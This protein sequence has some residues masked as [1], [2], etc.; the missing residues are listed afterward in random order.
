MAYGGRWVADELRSVLDPPR[1][2]S[3]SMTEHRFV[4]RSLASLVW[5]ALLFV[6]LAC[7]VGQPAAA[8][9]TADIGATLYQGDDF[10]RP[11]EFVPKLGREDGIARAADYLRAR[12]GWDAEELELP[13]RTTV[14]LFT[15]TPENTR[16]WI[17]NLRVR[18]VVFD[19]IP[20]SWHGGMCMTGDCGPRFEGLVPRYT[21][22]LEDATGEF[23]YGANG[24]APWVPQQN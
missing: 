20:Q 16:D 23:V 1:I 7:G 11:A 8:E 9:R 22:V 6:V 21:M 4:R 2:E 5:L 3:A 19:N 10:L 13:V 18:V 17:E 14:A 24:G 12:D 15:G